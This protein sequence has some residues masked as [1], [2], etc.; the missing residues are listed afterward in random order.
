VVAVLAPNEKGEFDP[1]VS[2]GIA[3]NLE[4]GNHH[5]GRIYMQFRKTKDQQK[6]GTK[7]RD[8]RINLPVSPNT[9]SL[10]PCTRATQ[11]HG[12]PKIGSLAYA[13]GILKSEVQRHP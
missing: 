9:N 13:A 3:I 5:D 1:G 4:A 12:S 10:E 8:F 7:I 11:L 6:A 2:R